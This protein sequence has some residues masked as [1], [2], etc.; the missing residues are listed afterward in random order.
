MQNEKGLCVLCLYSIEKY[1][2]IF[3]AN[4]DLQKTFWGRVKI[5]KVYS[6]LQLRDGNNSQKVIHELK[7][8]NNQEIGIELGKMFAHFIKVDQTIKEIDCLVPMPLHKKK[9]LSRGYNQS[10]CIAQGIAEVLRT[11]IIE[12][13]VKRLNYQNSQTKKNRL[14]RWVNV[15]E[16]FRCDRPEKLREKHVLIVDD[17]L[18]TGATIDA[19]VQSI[20]KIKGIKISV[21]ALAYAP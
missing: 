4:N 17:V 15:E 19:M 5:E 2:S 1:E 6:F 20:K 9:L 8:H 12:N 18:T 13:A 3:I 7:Y 16:T 10:S 21:A 14:E 11:P